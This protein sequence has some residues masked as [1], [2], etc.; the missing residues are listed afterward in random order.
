[1]LPCPTYTGLL[2]TLVFFATGHIAPLSHSISL[3]LSA[4]LDAARPWLLRLA[5]PPGFCAHGR[6]PETLSAVLLI[7]RLAA[8]VLAQWQPKFHPTRCIP[9]AVVSA[10]TLCFPLVFATLPALLTDVAH[11]CSHHCSLCHS[12]FPFAWHG[13]APVFSPGPFAML[14]ARLAAHPLFGHTSLS[15]P[16][17]LRGY[18][19]IDCRA[20]SASPDQP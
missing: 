17:L 8:A 14:A 11:V 18:H 3:G 2:R 9:T 6:V 5:F 16:L 20:E 10:L 15:I 12:P 7:Q 1:M 13:R 19:P 4:V